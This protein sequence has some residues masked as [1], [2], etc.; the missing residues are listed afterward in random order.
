MYSSLPGTKIAVTAGD[1][2]TGYYH[3]IGAS[4]GDQ[5]NNYSIWTDNTPYGNPREPYDTS[6]IIITTANKRIN[7]YMRDALNDSGF[8]PGI[9]NNDYIPIDLVNMGL[10]KGKDHFSFVMRANI[11]QD[12][13]LG[14]DYIY[15]M[16]NYFTVL[17]I[18]PKIP[19]IYIQTPGPYRHLMRR[20][21]VLLSTR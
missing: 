20:R 18:T 10:E 7:K 21:P 15:N 2:Y 11:F 19:C 13:E 8:S 1:R 6:T 5:I 17:R 9:M 16:E 4:M 14:W 12:P 3:F